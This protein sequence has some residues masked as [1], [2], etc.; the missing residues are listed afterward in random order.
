[1]AV[2]PR[3]RP[4][5]CRSG[6]PASYQGRHA[7]HVR[8]RPLGGD[9]IHRAAR[10]RVPDRDVTASPRPALGARRTQPRQAREGPRRPRAASTPLRATCRSSSATASDRASLDRIA[11]DTRAVS[12]DR[13]TVRAPRPRARRASCV[14]AGPTT[15]T[16]TGE[17]QFVRAMIDAHHARAGETGARIVHCCGYDSIPS[18]LGT[19]MVQEHATEAPRR[20]LRRGEVLRGR[21]EGRHERRHRGEHGRAHERGDRA[22]ARVRRVLGDP[23]AL[24]PASAGTGP[25][26]PTSVASAGTRTSGCGRAPSSWRPSTRASCVARTRSSGTRWGE[27]FRYSEAMSF[28]K[29]PKALLVAAGVSAGTAVGMAALAVGPVRRLVAD[30]FLPAPGEGPAKEVRDE[31]YFVTRLIGTMADGSGKV[32][33]KVRGTSDPGYGETAKMLGESAVCLAKDEARPQGRRRPHPGVLHG[34]ALGRAAARGRDDVRNRRALRT[35]PRRVCRCAWRGSRLRRGPAC[36]A[37]ASGS[38]ARCTG[39]SEE[40]RGP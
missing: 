10:R 11:V 25:T 14:E 38:F 31:G 4:S 30:R 6:A 5:S 13:G 3:T 36:R 33:G 16:C 21:G 35:P 19:L 28:G 29:G 12:L 26:D 8:R 18:D 27:D 39:T 37:G 9:R 32:R 40:G 17:P 22:I 34:H 7:A 1:M 2:L 15:A 23:Y 24:A 20:A